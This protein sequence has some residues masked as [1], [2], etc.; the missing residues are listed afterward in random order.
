MSP[1]P[2][3][4]TFTYA[5]IC[6]I[7][8]M[9]G[10]AMAAWSLYPVYGSSRFWGVAAASIAVGAG[11]A[12]LCGRFGWGALPAMG[13][14]LAAYVGI[15]LTL[16]IP[17]FTAGDTSLGDALIALVRGPVTGWKDMVTLPLPLGEYGATMLPPLL[18]LLV[19]SLV[20]TSLAFRARRWWGL[21]PAV[22]VWVVATA[23]LIG[24]AVRAPELAWAPYGIAL[25][26]EFVVG[27]ATFAVLLA[28]AGWRA[29]YMRRRA[30]AAAA[31]GPRLA[32]THRARTFG[33][34]AA[35]TAMVAVAVIVG[36][37]TAGLIADGTQRE[38]ART[39]IE[40]RLV[41]NS[42]VTPLAA[43]RNYFSD[44]AFN[45]PLFTVDVT[46]GDVSRVRVATLPYFDGDA[47]TA[48]APEGM[49]AHF[50][51]VPSGIAAP[52]GSVPISAQVT[53]DAAGGVWV[54]VVGAL[55]SVVFHGD[56]SGQLVDAFFYQ[57]DTMTGLVTGAGGLRAGDSYTLN[58][59]APA[60]QPTLAKLGP[61]PGGEVIDSSLVPAS[62][63]DWVTHQAVT[64]DGTG[65][66]VLVQRLRERGYL[67]HSLTEPPTPPAWQSALPGYAFAGSA[68]GSSYD[69][70]DRLFTDLNAREAQVADTPGVSLVAAVGD[71]EQFAAAVA[72]VAA[73]LGFPSRVVLGARLVDED[74]AGWSVPACVEG[75]CKGQNMAVWTEVRSASGVWIPIDVT[76]QHSSAPLPDVTQQRD[77]KFISDVDPKRAQPIAPPASQRGAG[78]EAL[79]PAPEA[80]G[81]WAAFG[82]LLRA[83]G[84][85][86]LALLI[87]VGPMLAIVVW[88]G[89]R[90]R[91]RRAGAPRD[92]IHD[93]WDEY[94]DTAVDAGFPPLPLSTRLETARA[95]GSLS[96]VRLAQITDHTTFATDEAG[97]Q[98]ADEF[99]RLVAAERSAWLADRGFWGRMR[100]RLS[101]RSLW[102]SVATQAPEAIPTTSQ[103]A[104]WHGRGLE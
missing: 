88:K 104:H 41:L 4:T 10:A 63:T 5:L 27:L 44:A 12:M 56:R 62:L 81:A 99:W 9:A 43:Y 21:A 94:L 77:P 23:V 78:S 13:L 37:L 85:S 1:S 91:R 28:W 52:P 47:F 73:D 34:F 96:G 48:S 49:T 60:G 89:L 83:A 33:A 75:V 6:A 50:E 25:N 45:E 95:Y 16:A 101:M 58:A 64:R 97:A 15:G 2:R 86:L 72:L 36:S 57:A 30:L 100:M 93:G 102:H 59:F 17:S 54:P 32:T 22:T 84:I 103:G 24:P 14:A 3:P 19:G 65:L 98:D 42:T 18:L 67:S 46:S 82:P 66:S 79:P 76:P 55:G 53:M 20:S 74:P 61:A 80:P 29:A 26:R 70:I 69:R 8:M 90:R 35:G 87:I 68:A 92:A 11:I 39:A 51:R 71:D 7:F 38:V 40:P 31:T